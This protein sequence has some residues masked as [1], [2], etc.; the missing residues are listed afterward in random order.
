MRAVETRVLP[1]CDIC[2][3]VQARID[4]PTK[5]GP[6]GYMCMFCFQGYGFP[7]SS[8]NTRLYVVATHH[9]PWCDDENAIEQEK[10]PTC[11]V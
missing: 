3:Q 11:R 2:G 5:L 9:G 8:I 10:C 1:D 7:E 4:G 6:H